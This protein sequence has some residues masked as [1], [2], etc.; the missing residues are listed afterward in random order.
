MRKKIITML[1]LSTV[2]FTACSNDSNSKQADMEVPTTTTTTATI[3]TATTE[4]ETVAEYVFFE[5]TDVPQCEKMFNV[6]YAFMTVGDW[7]EDK[8]VT[9]SFVSKKDK[10]EVEAIN[11]D[12]NEYIDI[13]KSVNLYDDYLK[14]KGYSF[15]KGKS[16]DSLTKYTYIKD[17][18][19]ITLEFDDSTLQFTIVD[20]K[21]STYKTK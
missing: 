7:K 12:F 20:L 10:S 15:K 16:K 18:I 3:T 5:N 8:N 14:D 1:I 13:Q 19:K 21:N 2:A 6:K 4:Q 17:N 9:Y 11:P